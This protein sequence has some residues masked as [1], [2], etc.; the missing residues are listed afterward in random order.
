MLQNFQ[1]SPNAHKIKGSIALLFLIVGCFNLPWGSSE[2]NKPPTGRN[3]PSCVPNHLIS[4]NLEPTLLG[5]GK[6]AECPNANL[7][8]FI[9]LIEQI[10]VI[11]ICS[12][13]HRLASM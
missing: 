5:W 13:Y 9:V 3:I 2:D 4:Q 1:P 12:I 10:A 8:S 6:A 7:R 11:V